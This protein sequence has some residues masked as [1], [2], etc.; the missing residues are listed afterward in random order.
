MLIEIIIALS[1]GVLFGT[2][3]GLI[4]GIHIN[5]VSVLLVSLVGS[6]FLEIKYVY[7]LVFLVSMATTHTFIDFIPSI[8]LGCPDTDTGLSVLPGHQLLKKGL[9][10]QAVVLTAYGSLASLIILIIL[11]IPSIIFLPKIYPF[12]EKILPYLLILVSII[13]I[14]LEKQKTKASGV[15]LLT[16]FLGLIVLNLPE[17]TLSQPLFPLLTGL[18]GSSMLITSIKNKTQITEQKTERPKPK[19]LKPLI[20]ATI[21]CPLCGFLPGLGSAQAAII[22]NTFVKT[23]KKGFLI[24][25]GATNTLVMGV[26][27]LSVYAL[28][29]TRTGIALSIKEIFGT[30]GIE[31]LILIIFIMILS[32][33]ISFFLTIKIAKIFSKQ[34]FKIN[35]T[36]LSSITL[37]I[38]CTFVL[39]FTGFFGFFILTLSTL[40]GYYSISLGV[41]RSNMMGCLLVPTILFYLFI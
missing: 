6:F 5:L 35:Y 30:I 34:L 10:F 8:F 11:L 36:L 21:A 16:G 9:G 32:G 14:S 24:L 31:H 26:S 2:L 18:F 3:T 41:R 28:S 1:I 17:N 27:F 20:G 37:L 12:I 22:G 33:I 4:P 29:K 15:F 23:D 39:I 19:L 13:L 38:L 7:L 40:T 25:L